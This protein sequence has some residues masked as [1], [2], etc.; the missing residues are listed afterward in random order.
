KLDRPVLEKRI[1][2]DGP[3]GDLQEWYRHKLR[4]LASESETET[5]APTSSGPRR[6]I[7]SLTGDIDPMDRK[8]GDLMLS[9][10]LIDEGTLN[11]LLVE[12][13]R[14]R[15]SLRQVLLASGAVTL[16]QM[17]L[18]ETGNLDAL[19]LGPVRVIDR[20]RATPRETVYRVFD[21]RRGSDS[22]LRLVAEAE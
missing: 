20:L 14:Q 2:K 5:A 11:S 3:L 12:W 16:F 9:L 19:M 8:L 7:L 22:V 10:D 4:G 21:P 15:R 18:I 6:D 13:R 1:P 17:A